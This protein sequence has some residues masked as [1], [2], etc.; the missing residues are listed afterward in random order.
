MAHVRVSHVA[1]AACFAVVGL[2]GGTTA[3]QPAPKKSDLPQR[4]S[5]YLEVAVFKSAGGVTKGEAAKAKVA[6][7][8]FAKYHAEYVANPVTHTAPQDFR[9]E[10]PPPGSPLTVDGLINEINRHLIIPS[11]VLVLN[12]VP[13]QPNFATATARD[14]EMIAKESEYIRELGAALDKALGDV[15]KQSNERVVRVNA[16][17]MLAA[18]CRSGASAH[19]PTVTEL[20]TA[21]NMDPEVRYYA[22]QAAGNLLSAYDI[23]DY[24]SRR[25]AADPKTVGTLIAAIQN[26]VLKADAILPLVDVPDG[27]GANRKVVPPDQVPVLQ[28]IRRQGVRALAQVRFAEFEA[29]KGKNLYPAHTLALVALTKVPVETFNVSG[30]KV[31]I[32]VAPKSAGGVSEAADAGEAVLGILNMAPPRG[33]A[34]AKQYAAPMADVIATGVVTW[35]GPRSADPA[36]KALPWKGTALRLD[37][38]LKTWQG[39]YDVN[40]N[41]AQPVIRPDLVPG[42]AKDVA[43][44]VTD[45]VLTPL[46][47]ATGTVNVTGLQTYQRDVLRKTKDLTPRPFTAPDS[48]ALPLQ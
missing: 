41:P 12:P 2:S 45:N 8:T 10:P 30:E 33:G 14:T 9:P 31:E 42:P 32:V 7:E 47:S 18:A 39:L 28:F 23:N 3:Q 4:T 40:W 36:S 11:P 26:C 16:T 44:A 48:P 27:K 21:P 13:N 17:R 20:L 6:F 38:G 24:R 1:L 22:L 15:V 46:G 19:W 5:Q 34:A 29:E 25:H 43:K 37:E 35:V